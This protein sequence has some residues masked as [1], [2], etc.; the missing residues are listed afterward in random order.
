MSKTGKQIR[1]PSFGKKLA[2]HFLVTMLIC[3]LMASIFVLVLS[4]N[5]KHKNEAEYE[6]YLSSVTS[7]IYD[8]VE[9]SYDSERPWYSARVEIKYLLCSMYSKYGVSSKLFIDE[10]EITDS[11]DNVFI[12]K[13]INLRDN[14]YSIRDMSDLD[15]F[16]EYSGG[17]YYDDGY[18]I[19]LSKYFINPGALTF[20]PIQME[21][22]E[23]DP[24]TGQMQLVDYFTNE[25]DV[26]PSGH[27]MHAENGSARDMPYLIRIGDNG[28]SS[29]Y[30][31]DSIHVSGISSI[32]NNIQRSADKVEH[33][34]L[35]L[36]DYKAPSYIENN[37]TTVIICY[38]AA[39]LIAVAGS[40][41]TSYVRYTKEK[42]MYD[43]IEY[44]RKTTNAMAHDLKTPLAAISAYAEN[45]EQDIPDEKRGYYSSKIVENVGVMN[46]MIEEILQFSKSEVNTGVAAKDEVDVALLIEEIEEEVKPLFDD[47]K[48]I[49]RVTVNSRTVL[50][51]DRNLLKQALMNL[52]TNA[53][54]YAV[55][56]TE[57]EVIAG[58]GKVTI[59][60]NTDIEI[61]DVDKLKDPF[62]KGH[63]SRGEK[64]GTGLGLSIADNNLSMLGYKLELGYEEG[65]FTATVVF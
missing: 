34:V 38:L 64:D 59:K 21:V 41:V 16:N 7:K 51:T 2:S 18:R 43:M 31:L 45:L 26:F 35:I 8:I 40:V 39:L 57:T 23:T 9:R 56:A 30:T 24:V 28:I 46:R 63:D 58:R 33:T 3:A 10:T 4:D 54:K 15:A 44:R 49:L 22:E 13:K 6:V 48:V 60:N 61:E 62:V 50:K 5:Y 53:A 65:V 29:Q 11:S 25:W 14:I 42:Y 37:R 55:P 32:M 52:F 36:S 27:G 1:K 12:Q 20:V 19:T 17:K 47:N